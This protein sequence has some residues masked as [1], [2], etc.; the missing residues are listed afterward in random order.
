MNS[1][2]LNIKDYT[3]SDLIEIFDLSKEYNNK[4]LNE[5][6]NKLLDTINEDSELSIEKK[7]NLYKFFEESRN[8]LSNKISLKIA[9][10]EKLG[11]NLTEYKNTENKNEFLL[12]NDIDGFIENE[13]LPKYEDAK[14]LGIIRNKTKVLTYLLNID[15]KFRKNYFTTNTANFSFDI[16]YNLKNVISMQLRSIE[17]PNSWYLFDEKKKTNVFYAIGPDRLGNGD[18]NNNGEDYKYRITINSGNYDVDSFTNNLIFE[19]YNGTQYLPDEN[20][21]LEIDINRYNGRTTISHINNNNFTLDFTVENRD[22]PFNMGWALGY[23]M[24][25]YTGLDSYTSEGIYNAG[26]QK[27]LFFVVKDFQ[28]NT[29]DKIIALFQKSYMTKDILAKIPLSSSSFTILFEEQNNTARKRE[30]LNPVDINRLEFEII[31]EYGDII[32]LNNMDFSVT[33]QFE[34]LYDKEK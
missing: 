9:N 24:N 25:K 13:R 22:S 23:R 5:Q 33:L 34:C 20:F 6:Y 14:N 4:Q 3:E 16:P 12:N 11:S 31:D 26:T 28:N 7:S 15:S 32:N 10:D 17:L 2:N 1:F 19:K 27:Y 21:P 8:I 29:N 30:Y 18:P